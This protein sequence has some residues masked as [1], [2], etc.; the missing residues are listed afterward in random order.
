MAPKITA[1]KK[2]KDLKRVETGKRLASISNVAKERKMRV[3]ILS[4]SNQENGSGD[5]GINYSL[6]F[7]FI[8]TAAAIGSFY[9][10]RKKYERETKKL[11]TIK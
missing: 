3:K 8:G 6:V 1:T 9:Y 5:T 2:E 4:E 7:G 11:E 10:T